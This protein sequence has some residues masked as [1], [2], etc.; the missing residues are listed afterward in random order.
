MGVDMKTYGPFKA[1]DVAS[2]PA[3]NA[4]NLIRKGIAKLVETEP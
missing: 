2:L 1:E 3:Q 4:D